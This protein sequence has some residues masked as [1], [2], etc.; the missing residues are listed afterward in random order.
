MSPQQFSTQEWHDVFNPDSSNPNAAGGF[1]ACGNGI[2][3]TPT[4]PCRFGLNGSRLLTDSWGFETSTTDLGVTNVDD[5]KRLDYILHSDPSAIGGTALRG[6]CMQHA[7]IA[8]DLQA[9]PDGSGGMTWLSDHFPV[10]ADFGRA[11]RWCS[12]NDD[13]EAAIPTRNVR[14]FQFGPTNCAASGPN[15]ACKQDEVVNAPEA[16]LVSGGFQWFR[17]DQAGT[18][19]ID[20]S[21]SPAEPVDYVV[22][23]HSDLSRPIEPSEEEEGEFGIV[24]SMPEPPY[25]I[26]T[27]AVN[28]AGAPVRNTTTRG[29]SLR[30]HQHLCRSPQDACLLEPGL[31]RVAPYT[32]VWPTT[33]TGD[34]L[35][36]LRELWWRFKTSG[37][38]GGRLVGRDTDGQDFPTVRMQLEGF[39]PEAYGCVTARPPVLE[40]WNDPLFPGVL[41]EELEFVETQID[42]GDHDWE[43]DGHRDDL[44]L[45]PD[46]PAQEDGELQSWF[47]KV[48]RDSSFL[49]TFNVCNA[50]MTSWVSYLTDLTYVVSQRIQMWAELDDDL[51][52]E[53]NLRIYLGFDESGP[54]ADPPAG[55]S[56]DKNLEEPDS[57]SV[58]ALLDGYP[59]LRGYF[60]ERAW[61]NLW[62]KDEEELLGVWDPLPPFFAGID[63]LGEWDVSLPPKPTDPEDSPQI[64]FIQFSDDANGDDADYYYYWYYKL[65]HRES[66]PVCSNP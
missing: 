42:P 9:D 13:P 60:V 50:G 45:A 32:Y 3:G 25:Y 22:Y 55:A 62:E 52:A 41:E 14:I 12:P 35:T 54:H 2:S 43:D 30:V 47:I 44:R 11:A 36:E 64:P 34:P 27:F 16:I 61:P 39:T 40:R 51:G 15:P 38:K 4:E 1:Y 58:S 19:S 5:G 59:P 20:M 63:T 66:E 56:V 48:T 24:Y 8:W 57:G 18:Y 10:R 23:H 31:G 29:Y 7:M 28:G 26:R 6:R 53:D 37:V 49:D 17:I 65:C 33:V 46:L 21:S